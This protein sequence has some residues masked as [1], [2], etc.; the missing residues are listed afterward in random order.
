M[1]HP[2]PPQ[3]DKLITP[4]KEGR[5]SPD[6]GKIGESFYKDAVHPADFGHQASER[7]A[8]V[9]CLSGSLV[10][11]GCLVRDATR[12]ASQHATAGV[13]GARYTA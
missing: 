11:V 4:D 6:P 5:A 3:V 9:G 13:L 12:G 10:V 2:A 8:A 1:C 7:D